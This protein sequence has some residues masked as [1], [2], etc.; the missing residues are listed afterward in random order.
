[1]LQKSPQ[2]IIDEFR[3]NTEKI[4][5]AGLLAGDGQ[6]IFKFK[7]EL[8]LAEMQ[9]RGELDDFFVVCD[10]DPGTGLLTARLG[11]LLPESL[12]EGPA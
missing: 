3:R 11:L 8:M 12:S 1:M 7:Y 6:G 9:A 2:L 5:K 10:I 4:T